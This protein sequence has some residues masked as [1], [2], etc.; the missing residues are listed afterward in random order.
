MGIADVYDQCEPGFSVLDVVSKYMQ[1]P[2]T[3]ARRSRAIA[4]GTRDLEAKFK[5]LTRI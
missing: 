4:H 2:W 1:V 3:M 5:T